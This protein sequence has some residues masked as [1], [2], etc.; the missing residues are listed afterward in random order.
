MTVSEKVSVNIFVK[1]RVTVLMSVSKIHGFIF[2]D[3]QLVRGTSLVKISL[4]YVG[5]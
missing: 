4:Q 2:N 5:L 1:L 3:Y